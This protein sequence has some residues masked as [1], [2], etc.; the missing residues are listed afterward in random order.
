MTR[1][2]YLSL[3]LLVTALVVSGCSAPE[4]EYLGQRIDPTWITELP[5]AFGPIHS[6]VTTE[7]H[8][9]VTASNGVAVL[10][11]GNGEVIWSHR[12]DRMP[13]NTEVHVYPDS[14]IIATRAGY[15]IW[16]LATGGQTDMNDPMLME[17]AATAEVFV[18]IECPSPCILSGRSPDGVPLWEQTMDTDSRFELISDDLSDVD[19]QPVRPAG[20]RVALWAP[21]GDSPTQILDAASGEVIT[22][23]Q[24]VTDNTVELTDAFFTSA[25]TFTEWGRRA[26]SRQVALTTYDTATGRELWTRDVDEVTELSNGESILV[27]I[28]GARAVLDAR[29]GDV[30]YPPTDQQYRTILGIDAN[31]RYSSL[32]VDGQVTVSAH[33]MLDERLTWSVPIIDNAL[34]EPF[35]GWVS[36][37][38]SY[39]IWDFRTTP[40]SHAVVIDVATGEASWPSGDLTS[41]RY[42]DEDSLLTTCGST[43]SG[44]SSQSSIAYFALS[45]Y[46]CSDVAPSRPTWSSDRWTAA[47]MES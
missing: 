6:A 16:D 10:D 11:R 9:L 38:A 45:L 37:S 19:S 5:T 32:L 31:H 27:E 21:K 22:A 8:V 13:A 4:T 47:V 30:R 44:A 25:D 7:A 26:P 2:R 20:D 28:D 35:S 1:H 34:V 23:L 40:T 39:L 29:T 33:S 36:L 46:E 14:V 15:R 3:C 18:T 12:E 41:P 42:H 43:C 24:T 17:S